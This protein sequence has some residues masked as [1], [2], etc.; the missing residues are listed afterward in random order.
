VARSGDKGNDANV[1]VM[2]RR[3]EYAA[4]IRAALT[5]DAVKRYFG[6][7]TQGLVERFELPGIHGFNF[8]LHDSLGGGGT[9]SVHVDVQAKTYGQ[10]LLS[11]PVPVP[12]AWA[13]ELQN[14]V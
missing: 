7:Y 9:S 8:L 6:H 3:P 2:A 11:Y 5:A 10:L 13:D 12:T 1:G 14:A 4:A